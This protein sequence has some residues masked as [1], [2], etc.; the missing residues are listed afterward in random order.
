MKNF[1]VIFLYVFTILFHPFGIV[2]AFFVL[3]FHILNQLKEESLLDVI[4]RNAKFIGTIS[5]IVIVPWIY[6]VV[7]II[8]VPPL[9]QEVFEYTP[10][11]FSFSNWLSNS[12][13]SQGYLHFAGYLVNHMIG[14]R[15]LYF[16]LFGIVAAFIISHQDR[17]RQLIY[18][19]T[20]VFFP[21]LSIL[22]LD[23]TISYWF[24]P[25]QYIWVIS[26][27]CFFVGWCWDSLIYSLYERRY[28][29]K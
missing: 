10:N 14:L 12:N 3:L 6:F 28:Y 1:F 5:A 11:P 21:I 27:N 20:L 17:H 8:L 25:R 4:R 15:S 22:I 29:F 23:V 2:I 7:G 26:L 19:L 16:L 9:E 13:D 24:L 18:F